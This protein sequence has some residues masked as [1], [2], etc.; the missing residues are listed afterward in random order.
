[1]SYDETLAQRVRRTLAGQGEIEERRMFGG[2]TFMLNGEMCCGV[3]KGRLMVRVLPEHQSELLRRPG[4]RPMDFTGRPLKGFLF[5]D[6]VGF[7]DAKAL[8]WW[9]RQAVEFVLKP[10]KPGRN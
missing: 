8:E 1:M 7:Q 6:P 10:A 3:D 4:A 2:L 9:L 5:I